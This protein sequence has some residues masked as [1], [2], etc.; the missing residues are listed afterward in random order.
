[1]ENSV[2]TLAALVLDI[3]VSKKKNV[4]GAYQ[5][6]VDHKDGNHL[7]NLNLPTTAAAHSQGARYEPTRGQVPTVVHNTGHMHA[8]HAHDMELDTGY[9]GEVYVDDVEHH[10]HGP[11]DGQE[12]RLMGY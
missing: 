12:R 5:L 10:P 11:L 4:R 7:R 1:V 8:Q 3:T 6:P 2:C 9:H